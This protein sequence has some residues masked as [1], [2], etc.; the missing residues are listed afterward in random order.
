MSSDGHWMIVVRVWLEE[1]NTGHVLGSTGDGQS[2]RTIVS[3]YLG[4][5]TWYKY[6]A[7][8]VLSS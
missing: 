3:R 8:L 5:C 1:P 2:R 4:T 6:H 7:D